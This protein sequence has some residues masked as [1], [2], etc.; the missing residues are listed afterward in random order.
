MN[1]RFT[2][3]F[4][5]VAALLLAACGGG[6]ASDLGTEEN[7]LIWALVPSQDT[8]AVLAGAQEIA[9]AVEAATG[10]VIEPVVTTDFT[11]AVEAMCS[12]E[13]HIGALNT[14]NYIVANERGC[15]EVELA[16]VR[17]GANYYAGQVI[18][19]VDS[20]ISSIADLAG[21][22]F[23][24]PDPTSTS[25]WIIP[26]ISMQ[27]EGLNPEEDLAE[28]VDAG[29][30]DG[31]VIAVYEGNCDAGSTF[32]DARSN[33]EETYP[34]VR[35]VVVVIQESAPIPNDTVS[36]HPDLDQEMVDAIVAALQGVDSE[37]LN[38]LYSWE[39]L[40]KV[41]DTFY[42]GFR[43]TLEAAGMSVEDLLD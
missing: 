26:S 16:S 38:A 32:V 4:I 2:L 9:A 17:F 22:T 35:D 1:K 41:D 10:Y 36:F 24:R 43:Q 20:G 19:H 14:F 34:D 15:A 37:T 11:A 7:P 18:T 12:G 27:A 3:L 25:G 8:D 29:G 6:G 5:A 40:D 30:H 42:D 28:I 39:S 21:M 33:V 13:A 23:C 31:V